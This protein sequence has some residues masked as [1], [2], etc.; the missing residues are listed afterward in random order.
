MAKCG[1][2]A[3]PFPPPRKWLSLLPMRSSGG[4]RHSDRPRR[5]GQ[6]NDINRQGRAKTHPL[7]IQIGLT[8]ARLQR[9]MPGRAIARLSPLLHLWPPFL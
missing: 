8:A 3:Q 9:F 7:R 6:N 2:H 5:L 4:R 1:R